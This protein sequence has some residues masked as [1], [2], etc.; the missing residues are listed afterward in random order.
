M[1]PHRCLQPCGLLPT[2]SRRSRS[3]SE[4]PAVVQVHAWTRTRRA[5]ASA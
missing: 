5:A 2:R 4:R 3:S 1:T